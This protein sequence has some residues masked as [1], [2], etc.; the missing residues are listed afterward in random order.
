[1]RWQPHDANPCLM[2]IM[3]FKVLPFNLTRQSLIKI[4]IKIYRVLL[5]NPTRQSLCQIHYDAHG[6]TFQQNLEHPL[7]IVV[8]MYDDKL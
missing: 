1:M 3:I 7:K 6:V 4:P 5:Y 2:Y 8:L